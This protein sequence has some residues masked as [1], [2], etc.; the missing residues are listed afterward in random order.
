MELSKGTRVVSSGG[1]GCGVPERDTL[2][3]YTLYAPAW[4]WWGWRAGRSMRSVRQP[5]A[6]VERPSNLWRRLIF[7]RERQCILIHICLRTLNLMLVHPRYRIFLHQSEI[8][9]IGHGYL[10]AYLIRI[11]CVVI[12]K[13]SFSK[14]I[15]FRYP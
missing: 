7:T 2:Y 10:M 4:H 9:R 11:F 5:R 6:L 1:E 14:A 15:T 3:S 8:Y 13:R 12:I